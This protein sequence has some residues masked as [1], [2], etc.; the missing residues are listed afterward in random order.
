MDTTR[1]YRCPPD[2]YCP[3]ATVK[4]LPCT[5]GICAEGS[6]SGMK[7]YLFAILACWFAVGRLIIR[8]INLVS[9]MRMARKERT[10]PTINRWSSKEQLISTPSQNRVQKKLTIEFQDLSLR[11][12]GTQI[13]HGLTGKLQSGRTCAIMGPSGSGKTSLI[14]V[15]MGKRRQTSGKV[16]INGTEKP[17]SDYQKLIGY[18]PQYVSTLGDILHNLLIR[19]IQG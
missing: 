11:I 18:V 14:S 2:Y 7:I 10:R 1:I 19:Q 4:P 6:D 16:L 8:L 12:N 15:L 9:A 5:L 13:L 3:L 17:I